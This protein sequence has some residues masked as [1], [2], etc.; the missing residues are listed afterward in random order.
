MKKIAAL[1]MIIGVALMVTAVPAAGT[2]NG[3]SALVDAPVNVC[4]EVKVTS[5]K[6]LSRVTIVTLVDGQVKVIVNPDAPGKTWTTEV[7]GTVLAVFV[8]SGNNTTLA[9]EALLA[10]LA[11]P[12]AV[13]GNSTGAIA[14]YHL[15]PGDVVN[16]DECDEVP[17]TTT[18]TQPPT[19][20][21]TQPPTTT[22][23]VPPTTTTTVPPTTTTTEPQTPVTTVTTAPPATDTPDTPVTVTPDTPAPQAPAPQAP[24]TPVAEIDEL[25]FGGSWSAL[26]AMIGFGLGALGLTFRLLSRRLGSQA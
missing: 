7:E 1:L 5:T 24:V 4:G 25:A 14:W 3:G 12:D 21:T 10:L 11:G 15:T 23:T 2:S 13:K 18:T 8:H 20:T 22:T 17:P 26:L 6:D 9:A 19:T 16:E